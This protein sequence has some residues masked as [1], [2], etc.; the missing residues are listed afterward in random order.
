MCVN[1]LSSEMR[2]LELM[3][4]LDLQLLRLQ[5]WA[6][7]RRSLGESHSRSRVGGEDGGVEYTN[8]PCPHLDKMVSKIKC[9]ITSII[10]I[11]RDIYMNI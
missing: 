3:H 9:K 1:T 8:A 4:A 2:L 11:L 5:K 7:A 6:S 10:Y